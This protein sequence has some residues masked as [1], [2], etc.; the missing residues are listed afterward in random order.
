MHRLEASAAGRRWRPAGRAVVQL[1]VSAI[2]LVAAPG[3]TAVPVDVFVI[4]TN[5]H[6][7]ISLSGDNLEQVKHAIIW[8]GAQHHPTGHDHLYDAV[9]A[10][11][12]LFPRPHDLGRR[13]PLLPSQTTSNAVQKFR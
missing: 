10:A 7:Q 6:R 13:G 1:W 2:V 11:I 8:S 5:P 12:D 9:R 3:Y 4:L